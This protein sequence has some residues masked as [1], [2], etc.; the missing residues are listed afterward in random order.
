L[1]IPV[2]SGVTQGSAGR[3]T[4]GWSIPIPFGMDEKTHTTT[5]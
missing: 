5:E 2:G 4:L 3:A 1:G